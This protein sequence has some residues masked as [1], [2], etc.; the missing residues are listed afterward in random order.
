ML[1]WSYCTIISK[2]HSPSPDLPYFYIW[3]SQKEYTSYTKTVILNISDPITLPFLWMQ[4]NARTDPLLSHILYATSQFSWS[5]AAEHRDSKF[6]WCLSVNYPVA[7]EQK[8]IANSCRVLD[9]EDYAGCA[10]FIGLR[11][12]PMCTAVKM[13]KEEQVEVQLFLRNWLNIDRLLRM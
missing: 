10:I 2:S 5:I 12:D 1:L 13:E 6:V 7:S 3:I 4:L 9:S 11:R 8:D